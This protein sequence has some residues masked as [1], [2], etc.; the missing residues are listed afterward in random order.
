MELGRRGTEFF[1]FA[2]FTFLLEL[3]KLGGILLIAA[4]KARFL[5]LEIADLLFVRE[6]CVQ[7]NESR[8]GRSVFVF[9]GGGELGAA[10]REDGHLE[11]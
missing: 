10:A 8:T 6:K 2:R 1:F 7:V 3:A 5:K 11:A 4:V 9:E